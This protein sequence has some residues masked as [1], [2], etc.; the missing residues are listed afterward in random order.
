[1][2]NKM[3][4]NVIAKK[5]KQQGMTL[6]IAMVML[7]VI[8]GVGVSAVKL[9]TSEALIASNDTLTM[10]AFQGAESAIAV[11]ATSTNLHYIKD[12]AEHAG[13]AQSVTV[14][15]ENVTNGVKLVSTSNV[16]Y[17]KTGD[18]PAISGVANSASFDCHYFEVDA[19][20]SV[21]GAKAQHIEGKA[22]LTP[23]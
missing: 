4:N 2:N 20:S 17:L 7:L 9:S 1:M 19:N 21:M 12:A 8:T 10:L 6:I 22:I 15:D 11:S 23:K 13:V 18:C 3:K 5:V 16:S 14:A